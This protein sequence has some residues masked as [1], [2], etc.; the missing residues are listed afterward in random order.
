MDQAYSGSG[1]LR[2]ITEIV[3]SS[4]F[5]ALDQKQK[6]RGRTI[7][8]F[9]IYSDVKCYYYSSALKDCFL[10]AFTGS[11]HLVTASFNDVVMMV[12]KKITLRLF[13]HL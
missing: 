1:A 2:E 6:V 9:S 4:H 7:D 8:A 11:S 5:G 3:N 12:M 13:S 10:S